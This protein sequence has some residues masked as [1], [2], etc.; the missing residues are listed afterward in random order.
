MEAKA[1]KR[2]FIK[3]GP[4]V[5]RVDLPAA[6]LAS[7]KDLAALFLTKFELPSE[8]LAMARSGQFPL[9][10]QDRQSQVWYEM[11]NIDDVYESAVVELRKPNSDNPMGS[12]RF[13]SFLFSHL[14]HRARM[15][16]T[17]HVPRGRVGGC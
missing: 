8:V 1:T 15:C 12:T 6:H 7:M 11:E 10:I 17:Q 3:F 13:P 2:V 9:Y 16:V 14:S 4:E 5:K